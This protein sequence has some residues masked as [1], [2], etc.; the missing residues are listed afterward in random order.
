MGHLQASRACGPPR[1]PRPGPANR[2]ADALAS[3]LYHGDSRRVGAS[4]R[5]PSCQSSMKSGLGAGSFEAGDSECFR[6]AE[7]AGGRTPCA[8][9]L[10]AAQARTDAVNE[11]GSPPV[12]CTV[13]RR[14]PRGSAASATTS[15]RMVSPPS[16]VARLRS[17]PAGLLIQRRADTR[18]ALQGR[19]EGRGVVHE[20]GRGAEPAEVDAH[21]GKRRSGGV[22]SVL[23]LAPCRRSLGSAKCSD[24][25]M[26]K[27]CRLLPSTSNDATC[28]AVRSVT[29]ARYGTSIRARAACLPPT[30]GCPRLS[31]SGYSPRTK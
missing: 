8:A 26:E 13:A 29:N 30:R 18:Q 14:R 10:P 11:Y 1:L 5:H 31:P 3:G 4:I 16:G 19:R 28:A 6:R 9:A 2:D 20:S 15:E 22:P 17:N 27:A 25:P 24:E 12:R 21:V 23:V 7:R